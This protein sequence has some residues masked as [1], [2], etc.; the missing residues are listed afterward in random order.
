MATRP[1][2]AEK[3]RRT[4]RSSQSRESGRELTALEVTKKNAGEVEQIKQALMLWS[5]FMLETSPGFMGR[6]YVALREEWRRHV[7]GVLYDGFSS[8]DPRDQAL[9]TL[10]TIVLRNLDQAQGKEYY[11]EFTPTIGERIEAL[12][13]CAHLFRQL[14]INANSTCRC[15]H[16][17]E[18]VAPERVPMET[19]PEIISLREKLANLER[20]P[21][22]EAVL[23]NLESEIYRLECETVSAD[24]WPDL[25]G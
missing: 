15:E 14:A 18:E 1:K 5:G 11:R 9:V 2:N 8:E 25:I 24:E 4:R 19:D 12:D 7:R 3:P 20:L 17:S 23:F 16:L 6:L 21:E 22:N 10:N 13:L